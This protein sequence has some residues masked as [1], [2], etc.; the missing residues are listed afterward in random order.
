MTEQLTVAKRT[1][2][3]KRRMKRLRLSGKIPAVL[4]GHGQE[5]VSLSVPTDQITA[6][7]RHGSHLVDLGGELSESALIKDVV[8]DTYGLE[9]LH[10]DL[11]RVDKTEIVEVT[12]AIH[13]RGVAP[14]IS[15]GGVLHHLLHEVD[16]SC[17]AAS[18]PDHL[19][20][21][22]NHLDLGKAIHASELKLPEGA[23]LLS[24][25]EKIVVE[26]VLPTEVSETDAAA[27]DGAEPE[28]IGRKKDEEGEGEA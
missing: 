12:V 27:G 8:W 22:V 21:S 17:T 11:A 4:Y 7:I 24:P 10:V 23:T 15:Q 9:V 26:C 1:E 5:V 20:V 16:M 2:T 13:I 6:A 28:V 18:I 25:G 14:G 19:E 3:G